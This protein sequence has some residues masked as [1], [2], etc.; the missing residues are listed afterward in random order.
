[1][2]DGGAA[3]EVEVWSLPSATVGSFLAGVPAPLAIGTVL[4]ADGSTAKGFIC[5]G[6]GIDGADDVTHLGGWRAA[7]ASRR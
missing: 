4:L 3:I 1:M 2:A 5:E 7:L 6:I